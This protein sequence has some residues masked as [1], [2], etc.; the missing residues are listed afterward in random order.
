MESEIEQNQNLEQIKTKE[1]QQEFLKGKAEEYLKNKGESI[2][3][4]KIN[5]YIS[6][7]LN[8]QII[9]NEIQNDNYNLDPVDNPDFID[10]AYEGYGQW[11]KV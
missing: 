5:D 2:T 6:N 8:E 4:Q 7:N 1:N 3:T 10:G 11:N 9:E